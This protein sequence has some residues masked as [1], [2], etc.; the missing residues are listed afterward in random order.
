MTTEVQYFHRLGIVCAIIVALGITTH[1]VHAQAQTSCAGSLTY[2]IGTIDTRFALSSTSLK[3]SLEIAE[4]VWETPTQR[5]LF[6]YTERA[7]DI[8]VNL[9]FDERQTAA[10]SLRAQKLALA[11]IKKIFAILQEK[12]ESIVQDLNSEVAQNVA[13]FTQY[14]QDLSA[15]NA[16]VQI[17]QSKGGAMGDELNQLQAQ[18]ITLETTYVQLRATESQLNEKVSKVNSLSTSLNQI[19]TAL[20]AHVEQYNQRVARTGEFEEGF[21]S[22]SGTTRTIGIY[23]F[24]DTAQLTRAFA[25]E[26]GHALG[27]QHILDAQAI[28][29]HVN[30]EESLVPTAGDIGELTRVCG[31]L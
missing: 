5:N 27:M 20:N 16:R 14:A 7:G 24:S 15:F 17:A 28:M 6:S 12:H 13:R 4:K 11:N 2:S 22:R 8:S 21:Y 23:A 19:V 25:H 3:Q 9:I 26:M 30:N 29:Y 18:K 31:A 1:R 10:L